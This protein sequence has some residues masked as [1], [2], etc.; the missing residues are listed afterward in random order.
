MNLYEKFY[1]KPRPPGASATAADGIAQSVVTETE[2][3]GGL[4]SSPRANLTAE[5]DL[6]SDTNFFSGFSTDIADGGLFIATLSVL[7]VGSLVGVSFTM[8]SGAKIE[9][10]GE[11]R[12]V[13]ALDERAPTMFPGMGIRFVELSAA[14]KKT[15][16]D[17]VAEREPMFFPD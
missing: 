6:S 9:A 13:R 7:P 1:E 11:V 10:K 5:V 2:T 14:A 16:A 3:G 4:R 8:P 12:W 15:I 17:F